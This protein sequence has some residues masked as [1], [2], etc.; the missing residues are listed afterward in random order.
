SVKLDTLLADSEWQLS[1]LPADYALAHLPRLD[2]DEMDSNH[3]LHGR[4]PQ[5][6]YRAGD[7]LARAYDFKGR[8]AAILQSNNGIWRPH[9]VFLPG[10]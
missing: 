9:K 1:L 5:S 2:L 10:E 3:V 4:A 7:G 6:D 8:L